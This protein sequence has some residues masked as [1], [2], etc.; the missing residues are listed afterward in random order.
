LAVGK[1]SF[2]AFSSATCGR[3]KHLT[4]FSQIRVVCAAEKR[5]AQRANRSGKL[6]IVRAIYK[7]FGQAANRSDNLQIVRAAGESLAEEGFHRF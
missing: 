4:N 1:A 2:E 7:L 5:F 3:V 6:Q